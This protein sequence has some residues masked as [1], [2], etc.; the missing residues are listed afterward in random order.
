M[1]KLWLKWRICDLC[2]EA[3]TKVKNLWLTWRICDLLEEAVTN[4]WLTWR[5]CDLHEEFVTYVKDLW[6]M[7]KIRDLH[8]GSVTYMKNIYTSNVFCC[9]EHKKNFDIHFSMKPHTWRTRWPFRRLFWI[10]P[11]C[12]FLCQYG[13]ILIKYKDKDWIL[14][15]CFSWRY[16]WQRVHV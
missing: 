13:T 15:I 4:L 6:L 1:K 2:E 3:V 12:V 16:K 11:W 10:P 5:I 14:L 7:C 9:D 8:E